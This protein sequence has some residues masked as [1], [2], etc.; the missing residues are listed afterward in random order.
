MRS[1]DWTNATPQYEEDIDEIRWVNPADI[2]IDNL[3][4]YQNIRV[5]LQKH[6]Q[7]PEDIS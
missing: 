4:T 3:N 1:G 5:V 6:L 7:R 2:D